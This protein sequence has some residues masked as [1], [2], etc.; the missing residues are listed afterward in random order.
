MYQLLLF[1]FFCFFLYEEILSLLKSPLETCLEA[2]ED[3]DA[4]KK[5]G[6]KE[7]VLTGKQHHWFF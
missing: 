3:V 5:P 4:K 1:L 2:G 7:F 6:D